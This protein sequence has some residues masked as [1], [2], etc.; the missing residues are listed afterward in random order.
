MGNFIIGT[1]HISVRA[2]GEEAFHE[3]IRFYRDIL[4]MPIKRS[5]G[6]GASQ[7]AMLD[8]GDSVMEITS[9]GEK[10]TEGTGSIRHFALATRDVDGAV[11][12]VRAAGYKIS[13][14]PR[15]GQLPTI[16]PTPIRIAFC[17]G[18]NG[19]EIEFFDEK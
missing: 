8:T 4:G 18:P 19:E 13:M 10:E 7:G 9:N 1:H 16:P 14:E 5:W 11:E 12:A 3:T 2:A 15:D 6:A 17:I